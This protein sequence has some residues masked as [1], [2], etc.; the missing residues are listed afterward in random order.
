[1]TSIKREQDFALSV[2]QGA[3]AGGRQKRLG[4]FSHGRAG[5]NATQIG[6]GCFV[7]QA[8][9][10]RPGVGKRAKH[11]PGSINFSAVTEQV[12]DNNFGQ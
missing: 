12:H 9:S 7:F 1:M 5:V 10:A 6:P 8:Y 3:G 2:P 4:Q 11:K